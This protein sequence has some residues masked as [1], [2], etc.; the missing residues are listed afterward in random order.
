MNNKCLK[1]AGEEPMCLTKFENSL[2]GCVL[3]KKK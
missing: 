2:L 3:K 1:N